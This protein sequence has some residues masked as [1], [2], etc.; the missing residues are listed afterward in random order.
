MKPAKNT[1]RTGQTKLN[2]KLA[3]VNTN[4]INWAIKL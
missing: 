1:I 4:P 2:R 3:S